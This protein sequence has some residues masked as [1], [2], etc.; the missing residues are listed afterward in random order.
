MA[1]TVI[2]LI[3]V[4]DA[5]ESGQYQQAHKHL[6]AVLRTNPTADAWCLAA[7]LTLDRDRE[8]AIRHLKRALLLN[9]RHGR[10]LTLLGELGET[11]DITLHDVAEEITEAVGQQADHT[12]ILR[13]LSRT[14]IVL[15][16][17]PAVRCPVYG[18]WGAEDV[19]YR[20]VTEGLAPA[21]AHASR[22]CISA[23]RKPIT[24][25]STNNRVYR[26]RPPA[27]R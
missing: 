22:A 24:H 7:E 9:P 10:S 2:T 20:G 3:D 17:L 1:A 5:L 26:I 8:Q 15:E 11:K 18:I 23:F 19:L 14:R 25:V 13:R 16:T 27:R 12:P 6:Q 21:L 4:Q